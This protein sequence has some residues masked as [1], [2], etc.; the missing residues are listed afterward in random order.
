M[1]GFRLPLYKG[2]LKP[3]GF[4]FPG[5]KRRG[6]GYRRA[7]PDEPVVGGSHGSGSVLSLS[8]SLTLSGKQAIDFLS[9]QNLFF[10]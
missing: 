6:S 10:L 8:L 2:N 1:V 3:M 7:D 9:L 5:G 4:R